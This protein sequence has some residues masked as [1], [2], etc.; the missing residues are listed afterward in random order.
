MLGVRPEKIAL[1]EGAATGI[2]V[3]SGSVR[4][5]S[6]LGNLARV[7]IVPRARP[8]TYVTV[9]LHGAAWVPTLHA[10]VAM[11]IPADALRVLQ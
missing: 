11:T 1:A 10:D 5:V 7:E 8:D 3:I 4:A 6:Y 2:N 9:E